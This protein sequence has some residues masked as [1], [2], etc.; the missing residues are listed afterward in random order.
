MA[1]EIKLTRGFIALVD[2]SDWD[3]TKKRWRAIVVKDNKGHYAGLYRN[4][5]D[6]AKGYNTKALELHGDFA[7]LNVIGK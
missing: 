7:Q 2:D 5:I 1:K 3:N 6:A 4:I